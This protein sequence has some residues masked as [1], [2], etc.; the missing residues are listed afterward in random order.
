MQMLHFDALKPLIFRNLHCGVSKLTDNICMTEQEKKRLEALQSYQIMDSEVE[1]SFDDIT[2]IA[3]EICQVPIALISL[4]DGHRQW[5]KSHHGLD[6][7]ETP[8]EHAF[9]QH[10][11]LGSDVMEVSDA[12]ADRR[13]EHNPLVTGEPNIRF[14]AGAPLIDAEG[15]ALGTLCVID[16]RKRELTNS[17]K[18]CLHALSRQVIILMENRRRLLETSSQSLVRESDLKK[19]NDALRTTL[20]QRVQDLDYLF[21]SLPQ[22]IWT[23]DHKGSVDLCNEKWVALTGLTYEQTMGNGWLVA[24]HPE[25][26]V[27]ATR[28]WGCSVKTET[29]YT[30]EM[31]FR[32][33]EGGY[34]CFLVRGVPVKEPG[35]RT[36]WFG[37]CTDITDSKNAQKEKNDL[38]VKAN[39]AL[40]A[41]RLKSEFLATMS[42]EIRTPING[43]IGMTNLLAETE[44]NHEQRNFAQA[45][46]SS[47]KILLTLIND[48][49]DLSKVEAGKLDF[50]DLPFD[51]LG[52]LKDTKA[53]FENQFKAKNLTFNCDFNIDPNYLFV[54]DLSRVQQVVNNLLSNAL[55]FTEKGSV[56]FKVHHVITTAT[57]SCI[58]FEFKDT[59]IGICEEALPK[60]FT[61]FSQADASMSRKFGG[62]GLGLS[63]SKQLI[64]RMGGEIEVESAPNLGSTFKF[65]I[66]LRIIPKLVDTHVANENKVV[67]KNLARSNF[68]ILVVEDNSINQEITL[69]MLKKA[70]YR[71]EVVAN[72]KE[73]ITAMTK[74]KYDLILMDCQMPEMDG[75]EA[76]KTLRMQNHQIPIVALTANAFKEDRDKCMAAGMNDFLT[77]P[78]YFNQLIEVVDRW[79]AVELE[80]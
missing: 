52:L 30:N 39:S 35:E 75:Y 44:L 47:S 76:T 50:E 1:K 4:V 40:E 29:I 61:N 12:K 37:T 77:K 10:A 33:K 11:I 64:E 54:G 69:R 62:S 57:G 80:S 72:G 26:V 53:N 63:I 55:K 34:R 5:F 16:R 15:H 70:G 58:E 42:H 28:K 73:A 27:E 67:I 41:S 8:R 2:R 3:S 22:I 71:A 66:R 65:N 23:A 43:I 6:A 68:R 60:L 74:I 9:C 13:F 19:R 18:E 17:Q 78:L 32:D 21:K 20:A 31:R 25:D 51:L 38:E 36:R 46:G 59:G 56:T 45:I 24:V 14:Y 49:L 7:T 48:I 79:L